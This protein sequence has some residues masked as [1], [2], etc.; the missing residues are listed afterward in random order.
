VEDPPDNLTI[1]LAEASNGN[2]GALDRLIPIVYHELHA[3][4]ERCLR[5]ERSNHT[6]QPTALVNE[7]YVRL[8]DQRRVTWK[9]RAHFFGVAASLM[10]RIL[11]DHAR[12]NRAKKR[13]GG[14][15][16]VTLNE[17]NVPAG[18]RTV[19]LVLLDDALQELARKDPKLARLV[20][21]KFFTGL[22]TKETASVLGVST[23]T[24]ER[25]W[26]AARAWLFREM[27]R[28]GAV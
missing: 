26:G 11:V 18:E 3:I 17:G 6:L 19:D 14:L 8:I 15:A 9:N 27:S 24:V 22:T 1:L 10:R 28:G 4:A 20:E 25:E 16:R 23:A 2:Q 13:A 5:G 21:L 12:A 7:A